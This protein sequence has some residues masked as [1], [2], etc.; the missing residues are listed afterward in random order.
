MYAA[1]TTTT[2]RHCETPANE[3]A[4]RG[5]VAGAGACCSRCRPHRRA[6]RERTERV[7]IPEPEPPPAPVSAT[8]SEVLDRGAEDE[9]VDAVLEVAKAEDDAGGVAEEYADRPG[10]AAYRA[11]AK[12]R[13]AELEEVVRLAV[14]GRL[15]DVVR[16][17]VVTTTPDP[18]TA[19]PTSTPDEGD[20]P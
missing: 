19:E 7:E 3:C 20:R 16:R 1:R 18:A 13:G 12:S 2:C 10:V 11:L 4:S 9:L 8:P 14:R 5:I 6:H 15:A 17:P